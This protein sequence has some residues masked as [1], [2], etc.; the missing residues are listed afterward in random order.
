[1]RR[2]ELFRGLAGLAFLPMVACAQPWLTQEGDLWVRTFHESAAARPKVRINAHGPVTLEGNVSANFEFTVKVAVRAR[3]RELARI[4]LEKAELRTEVQNDWLVL[5]TPGR[6]AMGTVTM[7]APRLREAVI[8]SSDGAV[9]AYGI[10]GSLTVD[11]GADQVKV[12]RIHGDCALATGGGD[13]HAGTVDGYL[14]CSTGAGAITAKTVKGEAV[15]RTNGGDITVLS[16]G[17]SVRAETGGGTVHL[18]FINGPVTAINGGG[19]IVVDLAAGIVTTRDMAG[20]VTVREAA[21]IRCDSANGGIQL[22]RITGPMRVSTAMGSIVANLEGSKLAESSLATA[23]GDITVVIPSNVGVRI[24]A[25]NQMA[26][27]IRRILSDFR[28]IQPRLS[29]MHLAAEGQVNGGGPLLQ[30]SA[31]SGTIFLKRQ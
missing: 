20:P 10:D 11:T 27:S 26:D 30:L 18:G 29:G 12:D 7:R 3:T 5:T 8:S 15:V 9:E 16:V 17:G 2:S 31:S 4:M 21:G 23:N 6:D 14:H 24:S 25:E 28:E 1:M 22:G 19:P 13:I